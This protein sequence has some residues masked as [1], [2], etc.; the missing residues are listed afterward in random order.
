MRVTIIGAGVAGLVTAME[1]AKR[2][3]WVDVVERSEQL[4]TQACAWFAG[5]MLAPW[6]EQAT[7]EPQVAALGTEAIG[8]WQQHVEDTVR[9]GTLVVAASRDVGELALFARRTERFESVDARQIS[10]LEPEL[11]GR[12][13]QGLFF[14]DEAHLDPRHAM[15]T[16]AA[17][18]RTMGVTIRYGV[19]A[20]VERMET[21]QLID[22]RGMAARDTLKDLRG[23]RGEMILLRAPEIQL[24]RPVRLLHP[25]FGL[26]VVPRG[27][28]I[29][30][31][32]GTLLESSSYAPVTV[33]SAMD[34][35]NAAYTLHPAFA[36]GEI[37]ELG[38]GVRP[39]FPDNLPRVFRRGH[40]IHVNGL[41]RHGFLLAP[42][43][44][45]Q[46]A[47]MVCSH[48]KETSSCISL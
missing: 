12:F 46:A 41:Y 23:V 26:Y 39:A 31:L 24:S 22:C 36:E 33:R 30:M 20:D 2:G 14:A 42:A 44:A 34:I 17:K 45:L 48:A 35:L 4:G 18:L 7:A 19:N 10:A 32:G 1:L 28:G 13:Q 47:Q 15:Q 40:T 21:D 25:R 3:I 5:G 16:L 29:F 38:V 11:A 8:W 9:R 27:D 6:C 37:L 43:M